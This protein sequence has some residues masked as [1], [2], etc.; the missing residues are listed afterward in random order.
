MSVCVFASREATPRRFSL[1]IIVFILNG[2]LSVSP[3]PF[4]LRRYAHHSKNGKLSG[5]MSKIPTW[6]ARSFIPGPSDVNWAAAQ[7]KQF[8]S[9]K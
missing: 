7:I 6:V 2:F 4:S 5:P 8:F 1:L 3:P 9:S